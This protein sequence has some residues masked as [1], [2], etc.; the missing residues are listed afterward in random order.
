[1][2]EKDIINSYSLILGMSIH[3]LLL[4]TWLLCPCLQV[5]AKLMQC[6]HAI[7]MTTAPLLSGGIGIAAEELGA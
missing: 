7:E 3:Y 5:E 4:F 1:M 6:V 2:V